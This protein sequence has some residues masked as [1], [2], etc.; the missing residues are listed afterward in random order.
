[1]SYADL[2]I[3]QIPLPLSTQEPGGWRRTVW[4]LSA[5]S[6]DLSGW[7]PPA[8]PTELTVTRLVT[9][10]RPNESGLV[11]VVFTDDERHPHNL[12]YISLLLRSLAKCSRGNLAI[13]GI[14][15]HPILRLAGSEIGD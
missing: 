13:E 4:Q 8:V 1:M 12:V 2:P 9:A 7:A 11:L 3:R 15:D 6:F 10:T 5:L 14:E